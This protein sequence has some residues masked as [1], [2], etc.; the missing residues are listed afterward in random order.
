M[1]WNERRPEIV[2]DFEREVIGRVPAHVPK[3]TWT[4]T[5]TVNTL[6]GNIPV[7]A[8]ELSGH[9]DNSLTPSISVDISAVEVIPANAPGP[10]PCS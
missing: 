1:W 9:V 10:V 8:K 7:V 2:E 3:V 4:V 5:R 6:V